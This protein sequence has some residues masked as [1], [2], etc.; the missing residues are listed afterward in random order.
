M[1]QVTEIPSSARA[2][3]DQ[4]LIG[5]LATVRPDGSPQGNPMWFAFDEEAGTLLFTHTT[6]RAK[7]RNLAANPAMSFCLLDPQDG[8]RYAEFRGRL[9]DTTP[10]P[11][12]AFYQ[13]LQDRY[14]VERYRSADAPDRVVL[15]M[16]I[17]KVVA[18]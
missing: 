6:Q 11:D 13:Q 17:D 7:F 15:T 8:Y 9:V 10:D 16:S 3:L 2:L 14:G 18:A 12:I 4:P 5:V 1:D